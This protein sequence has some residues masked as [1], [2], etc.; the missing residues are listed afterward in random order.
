MVKELKIWNMLCKKLKFLNDNNYIA[1]KIY[2][3]LLK[4]KKK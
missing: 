2:D 3:G 4:T 1:R